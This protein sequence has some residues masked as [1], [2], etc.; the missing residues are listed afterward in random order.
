MIL[1]DANLLLYAYDQSSLFH[2]MAKAWCEGLMSGPDTVVLVPVVAFAFGSHCNAS[3]RVPPTLGGRRGR[4]PRSLLA[5][6]QSCP[7][8]RNAP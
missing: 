4:R 5:G 1:P 6:P 3:P 7:V 8:A 2:T